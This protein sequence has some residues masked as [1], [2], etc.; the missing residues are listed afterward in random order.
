MSTMTDQELDHLLDQA[1]I[2][3]N[4]EVSDPWAQPAPPPDGRHQAIISLGRPSQGQEEAISLRR[5]RKDGEKKEDAS[6]D[7]FLQ[8]PIALRIMAPGAPE[9]GLFVYDNANTLKMRNGTTRVHE[10]LKACGN[11][12]PRQCSL[13]VLKEMLLAT[14]GGEN[15]TVEIETQWK[16]Q[17]EDKDP[18]TGE[19]IKYA[20]LKTGM[21]NFPKL[22]DGTGYNHR[23]DHPKTGEEIAAKAEVKGYFP[24]G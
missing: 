18:K 17:V 16:A 1:E 8:V 15:V 5:Q 11:P 2:E 9:D 22:S 13:R 7:P 19:V 12:P 3:Y 24:I 20:T 10:I 4:P 14:L 6:G 23:I 21:K